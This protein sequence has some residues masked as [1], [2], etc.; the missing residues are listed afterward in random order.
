MSKGKH[1]TGN[2]AKIHIEMGGKEGEKNVAVAHTDTYSR[3][4]PLFLFHRQLSLNLCNLDCLGIKG[5]L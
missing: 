5:G 1:S 3:V 4:S 2:D